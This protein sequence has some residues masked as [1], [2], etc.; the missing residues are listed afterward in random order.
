MRRDQI[1][2]LAV[3][4]YQLFLENFNLS[5]ESD[6]AEY[7]HQ[8][9]VAVKKLNALKLILFN[10]MDGGADSGLWAFIQPVYKT[11]GKV[12]NL[13]VIL[14][15]LA[16]FV[17][18]PPAEFK[19]YLYDRL[20]EKRLGHDSMAATVELLTEQQFFNELK[21]LVDISC[22]GDGQGLESTIRSQGARAGQL[23]RNNPA[24]EAWHEAR[25]YFKESAHLI[26]LAESVGEQLAHAEDFFRY[27]EMEQLLG[28]WHDFFMLNKLVARYE[29][30]MGESKAAFWTAFK[31]EKTETALRIEEDV[32]LLAAT[33]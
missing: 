8:F 9:R 23:V 3:E 26:L 32:C 25:R 24:G 12:R 6:E 10:G 7:I 14:D 19:L 22:I 16:S 15:L 2:H 21:E 27:R 5:L 4:Q 13:Q 30:L 33:F 11:G 28:R 29:L 1:F 17:V 18:E 31:N 20:Q